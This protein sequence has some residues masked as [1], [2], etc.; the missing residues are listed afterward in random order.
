[1]ARASVGT[2]A[3]PPLDATIA[4]YFED[5]DRRAKQGDRKAACRL[6]FDLA[7]CSEI[8][9]VRTV[10]ASFTQHAREANS[11]RAQENIAEHLSQMRENIERAEKICKDL[12]PEQIASSWKYLTRAAELGDHDAAMYFVFEPPM[13][14]SHFLADI[15]GW[16]YFMKHY[17]SLLQRGLAAGN[18]QALFFL[19]RT[20]FGLPPTAQFMPPGTD[21]PT[22]PLRGLTLS[23]VLS[24]ITDVPNAAGFERN[25]A[26]ARA[27]LTAAQI[28]AAEK[29]ADEMYERSFKQH[30]NF[31]FESGPTRDFDAKK[32]YDE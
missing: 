22:D 18:P 21:F 28:R 27:S 30:S 7:L 12:P 14:T 3:P 29:A 1:M 20:S 13:S 11:P 6:G 31:N 8:D 16:S 9:E 4:S 2:Y 25:A 15:E 24:R 26:S 10:E 19:Q 17:D 32:C 5:A 23:L